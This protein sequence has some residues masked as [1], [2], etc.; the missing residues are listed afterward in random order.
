MSS[1]IPPELNAEINDDPFYKQCCITG[2]TY[3]KIDRH[4][5]LIHAG[6]QVQIKAA[7]LPLARSIHEKVFRKD[8]K[9]RCD[10]VMTNRMTEQELDMYSRA[11]VYRR[12]RDQL[13]ERFGPWAPGILPP[14]LPVLA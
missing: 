7:I 13:N 11:V 10:W 3:E 2:R 9:D 5:N 1:H 6:K 12:R 8:I 4:H 14:P